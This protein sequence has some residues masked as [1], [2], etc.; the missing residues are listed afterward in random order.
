MERRMKERRREGEKDGGQSK[1]CFWACCSHEQQGLPPRWGTRGAMQAFPW[2]PPTLE[3]LTLGHWPRANPKGSYCLNTSSTA[4]PMGQR[5][6]GGQRRQHTEARGHGHGDDKDGADTGQ[7]SHALATSHPHR[8][9]LQMPPYL[10]SDKNE[11]REGND[12]RIKRRL[13]S[14]V[15]ESFATLW[16]TAHQAPLSTG[17]DFPAK[18]TCRH[19]LLQLIFLTQESNPHLLCLLH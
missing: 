12:S 15:S 8:V 16:T 17:W 19:F 7:A 11:G 14:V 9:Q 3:I 6:P 1:V 5:H 4:S 18:N 10:P 2:R 13:C